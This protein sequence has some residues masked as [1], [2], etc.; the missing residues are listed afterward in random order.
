MTDKVKRISAEQ[1]NTGMKSI[2]SEL[3]VCCDKIKSLEDNKELYNQ[4]QHTVK[5]LTTKGENIDYANKISNL[6]ELIQSKQLFYLNKTGIS[7]EILPEKNHLEFA[8]K[9]LQEIGIDDYNSN[10]LF[11]KYMELIEKCKKQKQF[12]DD[13]DE[14]IN[15]LKKVIERQNDLKCE[16]SSI[17]YSPIGSTA[18]PVDIKLD[19]SIQC[20]ENRDEIVELVKNIADIEKKQIDVCNEISELKTKQKKLYHELPPSMDQA[21]MAVQSAEQSMKS[22]SKKLIEKLENC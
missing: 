13:I 12:V 11:I 16:L 17:N 5:S 9:I 7:L 14:H 3:E 15:N 21:I 10:S 1:L 22:I 2:L 19:Q 6:E 4:M 18:K 20:V 8:A